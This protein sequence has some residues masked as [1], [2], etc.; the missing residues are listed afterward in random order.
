MFEDDDDVDK[1]LNRRM[2]SQITGFAKSLRPAS[3]HRADSS[4]GGVGL[5]ELR[6]VEESSSRASP[7]PMVKN[8]LSKAKSGLKIGSEEARREKKRE[9]LKRQIKVGT[10]E[11]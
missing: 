6:K 10:L 3:S 11:E 2:S 8:I 5:S 7:V 9:N 1:K 4:G